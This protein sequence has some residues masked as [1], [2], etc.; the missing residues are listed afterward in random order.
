MG[1]YSDNDGKSDDI[2]WILKKLDFFK[3]ELFA[4]IPLKVVPKAH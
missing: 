2:S 3:H 1:A 4:G